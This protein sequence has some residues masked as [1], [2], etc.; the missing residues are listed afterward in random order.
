M[1]PGAVL[2]GAVIGFVVGELLASALVATVAQATGYPGG[3][4]GLAS[5][6][7]DP[8]WAGTLSLV[9]LWAGFVLAIVAAVRLGG[10]RPWPHQWRVDVGDW[11]YVV[12][13][14]AAQFAV[15]LAYRPFHVQHLNRPTTKLFG[16]TSG[17]GFVLLAVLTTLGAP[18]VEE[19]FFRGVIFRALAA[20]GSPRQPRWSVVGAVVLS[21]VIFAA[22]HGE[23]VQFA[24]LAA[25]GVV[26]ATV[27]WRTRRLTPSALTHLSFNA[28]AMVSVVAQRLH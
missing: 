2:L 3:Y 23:P 17:A 27:A 22:A 12:L 10:L 24:G 14:I 1:R 15:G 6:T 21:A 26:L 28:V 13:G 5:A 9:G 11:R 4:A 19:W 20:V 16:A 8:W 25:L 7:Q 18:I